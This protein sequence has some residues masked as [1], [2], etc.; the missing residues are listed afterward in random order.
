MGWE[1]KVTGKASATLT[2]KDWG[3]NVVR[4]VVI[5]DIGRDQILQTD[6]FG[7]E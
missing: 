5:Q 6:N 2:A 4:E 1:L 3:G 7:N